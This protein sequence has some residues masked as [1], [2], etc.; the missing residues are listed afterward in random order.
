L[1]K[2]WFFWFFLKRWLC[3]LARTKCAVYEWICY[4]F[5]CIRDSLRLIVRWTKIGFKNVRRKKI[6]KTFLQSVL[7]CQSVDFST[8]GFALAPNVLGLCEVAGNRSVPIAIGI[9]QVISLKQGIYIAFSKRVFSDFKNS[10]VSYL[11]FYIELQL[12]NKPLLNR[13]K[14][15]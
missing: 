1:E 15:G 7:F 3:V 11:N 12:K 14:R 9:A 5:F 6:K 2:K 8:V 13:F 10:I 4:C